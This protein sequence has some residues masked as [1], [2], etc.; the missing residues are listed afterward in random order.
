VT[1]RRREFRALLL[2]K[3]HELPEF[4]NLLVSSWNSIAVNLQSLVAFTKAEFERSSD[5]NRRAYYGREMIGIAVESAELLGS[6]FLRFRHGKPRRFHHASNEELEALFGEL[7]SSVVASEALD[8]LGLKSVM[9]SSEVQAAVRD[10]ITARAAGAVQDIAAFWVANITEVRW[11]RHFPSALI[12]EEPAMI[13]TSDNASLKRVREEMA[14]SIDLLDVTV[15]PDGASFEY[16]GL[17]LSTA[18]HGPLVA[19]LVTQ[20]I[21]N[22]SSNLLLDPRSASPESARPKI[23]PIFVHG[24]GEEGRAQLRAA[25]YFVVT[26]S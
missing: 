11:F 7:S 12:R 17:R 15:H 1:I 25:G 24:L 8:F 23:Y 21:F 10:H 6:E 5:S 4:E 13:D 26:F 2:Q 20:V 3:A 18:L 19:R 14:A 16:S 22:R 9:A